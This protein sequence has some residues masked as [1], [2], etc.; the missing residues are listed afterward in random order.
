MRHISNTFIGILASSC[1]L[2]GAAAHA[3]VRGAN[4]GGV[5]LLQQQA[6]SFKEQF[7]EFGDPPEQLENGNAAQ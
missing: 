1:T 3:R 7:L 5:S 6:K 2:E 4:F